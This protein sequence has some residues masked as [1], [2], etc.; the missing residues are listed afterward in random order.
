MSEDAHDNE[1]RLPSGFV[2]GEQP[3]DSILDAYRIA[4]EVKYGVVLPRQTRRL[5]PEEN[6][7]VNRLL[8]LEDEE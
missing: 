3:T 4:L 1:F 8:G 5:T 2:I 6:D 7:Q